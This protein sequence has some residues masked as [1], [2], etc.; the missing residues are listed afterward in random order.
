MWVRGTPAP[1]NGGAILQRTFGIRTLRVTAF[2]FFSAVPRADRWC[3]R[4]HFHDAADSGF[5]GKTLSLCNLPNTFGKSRVL[6]YIRI[7]VVSVHGKLMITFSQLEKQVIKFTLVGIAAVLTDLGCYYVLLNVFPE[8]IFTVIDNEALAKGISFVC[9]IFVT[10]NF[11][12]L[13]TWGTKGRNH[14]R[15]VKFILLYGCSLAV[16]VAV[17]SSMLYLLHKY[18][19]IIDLP[20]KY[21]IAFIGATGVSAVLNFIGQKY[22]VFTAPAVV[23]VKE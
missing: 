5:E 6:I 11:N 19:G 17:N 2:L 22:W 7:F 16:N 12:K 21:L 8:R 15:F 9:G 23:L 20:H 18:R 10:Y 14:K 4:R 3:V 1:A 13:W